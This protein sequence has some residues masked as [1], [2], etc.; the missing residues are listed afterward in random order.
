MGSHLWPAAARARRTSVPETVVASLTRPRP[1]RIGHA[2]AVEAD[3]VVVDEVLP[4]AVVVSARDG[5]S[6]T[7]SWELSPD[8][9]AEGT[10]SCVALTADAILIGSPATGGVVKIDRGTGEASLTPIDSRWVGVEVVGDSVFVTARAH[11]DHTDRGIGDPAT[12]DSMSHQILWEDEVRV[13]KGSDWRFPEWGPWPR[14]VRKTRLS[15]IFAG[16]R[17]TGTELSSRA[18]RL[19]DGKAVPLNIGARIGMISGSAEGVVLTAA[20]A[21]DP[22]IEKH[23]GGRVHQ[24]FDRV[25]ITSLVLLHEDDSFEVIGK[26]R[27]PKQFLSMGSGCALQ[28]AFDTNEVEIRRLDFAGRRFGDPVLNH[29]PW[30]MGVVFVDD[31]VIVEL[32][33]NWSLTFTT[34]NSGEQRTASLPGE[35]GRHFAVSSSH[36]WNW[37]KDPP[38]LMVSDPRT[39]ESRRF[40]LPMDTRPNAPISSCQTSTSGRT[41]GSR[42]PSSAPC[43]P[44]KWRVGHPSRALPTRASSWKASSPT[45]RPLSSTGRITSRM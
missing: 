5:L 16:S 15:R 27:L 32:E 9:R 33:Q 20:L 18:W 17:D 10:T 30:N 45:P 23:A 37:T 41:N 14:Y 11:E 28:A 39:L 21:D 29:Y 25:V 36:I 42:S 19:R 1:L 26:L 34:L 35:F 38:V 44:A 3:V 8:H 22:V 24:Q 6:R 7:Y 4:L 13:M 12:S 2:D 43:W 31:V 40:P